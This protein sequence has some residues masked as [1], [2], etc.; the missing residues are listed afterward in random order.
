MNDSDGR[1][2][3]EEKSCLNERRVEV[4]DLKNL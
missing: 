1:N 4:C 2:K 3:G